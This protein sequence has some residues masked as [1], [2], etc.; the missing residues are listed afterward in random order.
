MAIFSSDDLTQLLISS[1]VMDFEF[2][3]G[4]TSAG[5]GL[6]LE[7][8]NVSYSNWTE[9]KAREAT[10]TSGDG[11]AEWADGLVEVGNWVNR[12]G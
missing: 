12:Q 3:Y 7:W 10:K 2:G 4:Y 5:L 8:G 1:W 9:R 6:G 11:D